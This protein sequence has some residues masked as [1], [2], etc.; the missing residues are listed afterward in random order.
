LQPDLIL[1][2]I[3]LPK[4][5]GIEAARRIREQTPSSKVLFLSAI[6]SSDV[7][8]EALR[9]GAS[10]YVV[11]ADAGSD[12]LIAVEAVLRGEVFVSPSLAGQVEI[13]RHHEVEF[14]PDDASLVNSF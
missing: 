5:S 12:L 7:A 11:K 2:D 9:T 3:G 4:I 6:C 13:S 1:L 14:C 8:E 10:G